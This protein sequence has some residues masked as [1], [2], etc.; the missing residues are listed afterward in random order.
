[1][2]AGLLLAGLGAGLNWLGSKIGSD[3][4]RENVDKT[5]AANKQ[6][7]EYQYSKD[8]EMWNRGNVYNDPQHQMER[9]R[10][11]G[12]NPNM[13]YGSGSA[14]GLSAGQ[15]P[16]YNAPTLNY[17]YTPGIDPGAML[18]NFQ[19][20]ALKQAQTRNQNF[21]Y[22]KQQLPTEE[23]SSGVVRPL[24]QSKALQELDK[25]GY[26]TNVTQAEWERRRKSDWINMP[27]YQRQ[28]LEA[29]TR[30]ADQETRRLVE[31][32]E[33]LNLQNSYFAEKAISQILGS[34]IGG[35]GK[36]LNMAKRGGSRA[37]IP[38]GKL[39]PNT[40]VPRWNSPTSWKNAGY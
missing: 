13:V 24:W 12:L 29:S 4:Q 14:A 34:G 30:R 27:S 1:M 15:L 32:T 11:A 20:V 7:A 2:P 31:A 8:L 22:E 19:D 17:N 28:A 9:L 26:Q 37:G 23:Y 6:M 36:L 35:L 10:K 25:L 39:S 3:T 5:I 16:K 38:T 33:N 18:A 40:I 21:N